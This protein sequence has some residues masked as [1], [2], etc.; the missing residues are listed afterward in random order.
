MKLIYP[1]I[2]QK[3]KSKGEQYRVVYVPDLDQY[4]QGDSLS[5]CIDM[6][7][8]LIGVY[9]LTLDEDK[10]EPFPTPTPINKVT[11]KDS[12]LVTLVDVDYTEYKKQYSNRSV[13]RNVTLPS[14][15]NYEAEK[16]GINVSAFLTNALK[17]E[18]HLNNRA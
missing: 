17:Q 3:E 6:A 5:D 14:W 1:V 13:R 8:D 7:R 10:N 11:C 9:C 2:I 12:E 16:S 4:T 18:L 15:V